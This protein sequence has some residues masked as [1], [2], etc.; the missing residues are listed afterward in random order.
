[1]YKREE[2]SNIRWRD[3]IQKYGDVKL[4]MLFVDKKKTGTTMGN[5]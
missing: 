5:A 3:D 2:A 1:M 4:M